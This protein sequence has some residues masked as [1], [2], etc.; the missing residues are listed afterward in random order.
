MS[1]VLGFTGMFRETES[2]KF[3]LMMIPVGFLVLFAGVVTTFMAGE[4]KQR[5]D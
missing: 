4:P 5:N 1:L 2:A 3:F